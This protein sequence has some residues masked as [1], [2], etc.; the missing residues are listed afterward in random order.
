MNTSDHQLIR[1]KRIYE[2]YSEDD[3]Y[4]VLVDRLWPRG[5]SKEEA[6]LDEWCK[7]IAPTTELRKWFNHDPGKFEEFANRYKGE[8]IQKEEEVNHLIDKTEKQHVTLLYAAKDEDHNHALVLK[9]FLNEQLTAN[10]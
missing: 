6:G 5:V 4:R 7:E 3:G 10:N 8:L 9:E 1:I 2:E